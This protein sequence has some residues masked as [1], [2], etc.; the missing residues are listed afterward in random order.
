MKTRQGSFY[1]YPNMS[2][3]I[4]KKNPSFGGFFIYVRMQIEEGNEDQDR[5]KLL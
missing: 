3:H 1:L 2:I 4:I 5:V